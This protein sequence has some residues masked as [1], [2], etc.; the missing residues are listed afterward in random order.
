MEFFSQCPCRGLLCGGDVPFLCLSA[1]GAL[2]SVLGFL[3]Y[4]IVACV[5]GLSLSDGHYCRRTYRY[6]YRLPGKEFHPQRFCDWLGDALARTA[7]GSV[8]RPDVSL[9]PT[10]GD[11]F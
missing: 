11:S 9:Y 6:W 1:A 8:L 10:T 3:C 7:S 2:R 4:L 5:P